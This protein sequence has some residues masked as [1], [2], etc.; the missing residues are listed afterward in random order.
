MIRPP[1]REQDKKTKGHIR[2]R[3]LQFRPHVLACDYLVSCPLHPAR[4][5]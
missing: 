5:M 1:V 4:R 2:L 3:R